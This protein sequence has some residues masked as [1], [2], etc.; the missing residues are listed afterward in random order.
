MS[1]STQN[2]Q[3]TTFNVSVG[4]LPEGFCGTPQQ[5]AQAI[6]DRLIIQVQQNLSS[7]VTGSIAPTSNVGPWLKDCTDW[8]IFDDATGGYIPVTK[9]G[10]NTLSSLSTSGSFVV[11]AFIYKLRIEAW[12]AGGGGADDSAAASGAGGGGGSYGMAIKTVVP[13]QVIPYVIG[14]GGANGVPAIAGTA[15]TILGMTAGGGTGATNNTIA[16]VGG[17]A[18]GFDFTIAGQG[19]Q[20]NSINDATV[21]SGGDAPRGGA[22]GNGPVSKDGVVPGGGGSGSDHNLTMVGGSGANGAILIWY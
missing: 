6:A 14:T 5:L 3:P 20:T 9:G 18:T 10:F 15:S 13:G 11:P 16:G 8:Y 19:G 4:A 21:H 22:G 7:F 17:T 1:C 2:Q 12:G